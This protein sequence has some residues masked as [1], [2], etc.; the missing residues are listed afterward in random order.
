MVH[1]PAVGEPFHQEQAPTRVLLTLPV[2]VAGVE[3]GALVGHLAAFEMTSSLPNR[4]YAQGF[5]RLGFDDDAVRF[6]DEHVEAD[7][8]HEVLAGDLAAGLA[9]EDFDA[10]ASIG[11]VEHVG[12]AA[13]A[14]LEGRFA[15]VQLRAWRAGESTLL[16]AGVRSW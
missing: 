7:S 1:A 5:R 6:F 11:M 13:M 12:D 10:I 2:A 14:L 3:A 8:V 9:A 16:P 4:G 15:D